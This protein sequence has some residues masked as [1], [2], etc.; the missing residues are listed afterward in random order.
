[1]KRKI[2]TDY[3]LFVSQNRLLRVILECYKESPKRYIGKLIAARKWSKTRAVDWKEAVAEI[4]TEMGVQL[5]VTI[6]VNKERM[7]LTI[8]LTA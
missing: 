1:M 6:S 2:K 7:N 8:I 4:A 5:S 3:Q